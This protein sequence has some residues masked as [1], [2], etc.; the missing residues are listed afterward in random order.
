MRT[1]AARE[2]HMTRTA[3]LCAA[4]A[5]LVV[6][7]A[8]PAQGAPRTFVARNGSDLDPCTRT[9]PCRTFQA[10]FS[11]TDPGGEI[12][13]LGGGNFSSQVFINKSITI[14]CPDAPA[15]LFAVTTEAITINA[16]GIIV[17]LRNLTLDG[18]DTGD[19]GIN[20][21]NGAALFVENCVING[22]GRFNGKGRAISFTPPS[23]VTAKLFVVKSVLSNNNLP[24]IGAG[25]A[26]APNGT[27]SALAVIERSR[28]ENN[29]NG[30]T[31]GS[32]GGVISVHVRN[33]VM[34]GNS[35]SIGAFS[36]AG[37]TTSV[38]LDRSASTL[39]QVG[40]IASGPQAFVSLA[41]TTI[42]SNTT[43]MFALN[44][45]SILSYQDNHL[46]GNATDGAPTG[47]LAVK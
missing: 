44:G 31:T 46:T 14:D 12:N 37:G 22:F 33:S 9:A 45:G 41:K 8:M 36:S 47:V 28:L 38:T 30:V 5:S 10:A 26:L 40:A 32:S 17:R 25:V 23:G 7:A 16:A 29:F 35:Q 19:I 6:M 39:N 43:G 4:L 34:A 21:L 27:G 24:G 3:R 1:G 42:I 11:A 18:N 20:F 13:C 2:E 15:T